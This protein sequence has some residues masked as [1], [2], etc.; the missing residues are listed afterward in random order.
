MS[1]GDHEG[2]ENF[3]N[4]WAFW[5][6]RAQLA[7]GG[8]RGQQALRDLRE[9]LEALPQH[10]L[11]NGAL[12]TFGLVDSIHPD[13]PDYMRQEACEKVEQEGEGVCAVGAYIWHKLV[14]EGLSHDEAFAKL[15]HLTDYTSGLDETAVE[16]QKHGLTYTLAIVLADLNDETLEGLTPEHRWTAVMGWIDKQLEKVDQ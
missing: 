6:H 1:R 2:E 10:R 14:K 8:K 11:V 12:S 15:P 7:I 13:D 3:P 4:E 16:G 9:A 5:Q